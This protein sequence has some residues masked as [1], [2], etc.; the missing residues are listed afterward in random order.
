M[1]EVL[2]YTQ[3]T[4]TSDKTSHN[5]TKNNITSIPPVVNVPLTGRGLAWSLSICECELKTKKMI[6]HAQDVFFLLCLKLVQV[7]YINE[8]SKS[9][10]K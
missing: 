7:I 5:D 8:Q 9:D 10:S 6:K 4:H 3:E 1:H 2:A